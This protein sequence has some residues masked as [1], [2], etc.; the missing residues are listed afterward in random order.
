MI[1][2][3]EQTKLGLYAV[4]SE[5]TR[6]IVWIENKCVIEFSDSD[7]FSLSS[8]ENHDLWKYGKFIP[9]TKSK[10]EVFELISGY[11]TP[12]WKSLLLEFYEEPI[13]KALSEEEIDKEACSLHQAIS[14]VSSSLN[15]NKMDVTT[16]VYTCREFLSRYDKVVNRYSDNSYFVE[17]VCKKVQKLFENDCVVVI[18]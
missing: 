9:L 15:R 5:N 17:Q 16:L 2:N 18:K 3:Y 1:L 10:K 14:S 4:I 6:S 11:S 13:N 12:D 8:R 7:R